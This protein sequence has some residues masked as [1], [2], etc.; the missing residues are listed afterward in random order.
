[1]DEP[2]FFF[3]LIFVTINIIQ[4]WLIFAYKLLI[5]GGIIIGAMEAVEIPIIL[6]LIIK[7]GIIGF[8]VVVFVEIVQWSFIAYFS[9]K[10][11][12]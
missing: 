5:R 11:K 10:S 8:L 6:Y 2:L 7:G 9:T 4:T 3:I 1:M 12:I